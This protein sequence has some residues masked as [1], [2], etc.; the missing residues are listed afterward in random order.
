LR[1]PIVKENHTLGE[2]H[3]S[4][5]PR[6]DGFLAEHLPDAEEPQAV[7]EHRHMSPGNHQ[8]DRARKGLGQGL[9]F[10]RD[11][12]PLRGPKTRFELAPDLDDSIQ[13][14]V[15]EVSNLLEG[16]LALRIEELR[17]ARLLEEPEDA[18]PHEPEPAIVNPGQL[19]Q[20]PLH[21]PMGPR[22]IGIFSERAVRAAIQLEVEGAA[23][24]VLV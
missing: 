5:R 17:I 19:P 13:I 8:S 15:V 16:M 11:G 21:L 3:R 23:L 9:S 12:I 10:A 1:R 6:D 14:P 22:E 7:Q 24:E 18:V 2:R 4:G 20:L